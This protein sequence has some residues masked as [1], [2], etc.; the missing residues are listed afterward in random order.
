AVE[1]HKDFDS[2]ALVELL[3][4]I[5]SPQVGA[6]VD[7][8]NSL[9]LLEPPLETVEALAPHAFS[10]HLKDLGVEEYADGFLMSEVP[11]GAGFLDLARIVEEL[12]RAKHAPRLNLEMITRDPLKIPCL[13]ERYW[14]TLEHLPG[15][16]LA[17]ALALVRKHAGKKPLPRVS[18][19]TP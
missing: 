6:C 4:A 19:L 17:G 16:R 10:T 14:A 2:K 8:G 13:T 7:T 11:L 3:K 12:R 18:N 15:R 5:D 1:N 9:A